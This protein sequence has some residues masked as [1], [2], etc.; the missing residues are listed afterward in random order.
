MN[1]LNAGRTHTTGIPL[2]G[3]GW[4]LPHQALT[5]FL[6]AAWEQLN[7]LHDLLIE[8]ISDDGHLAHF[9]P[10]PSAGASFVRIPHQ[11]VIPP[12]AGAPT[13]GN[14]VDRGPRAPVHLEN[15]HGWRD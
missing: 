15:H 12:V 4:T 7:Q 10:G 13:R 3:G 1:L 5:V 11:V 6:E 2:P 8:L 14:P 9:V